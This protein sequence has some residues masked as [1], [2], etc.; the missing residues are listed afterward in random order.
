MI[1]EKVQELLR[2]QH[3][4]ATRAQLRHCGLTEAALAWRLRTQWRLVLPRVVSTGRGRLSE[5]QRLIAAMLFADGDAVV[6]SFAAAAWHGVTAAVPGGPVHLLV[7]PSRGLASTGFVVVRRTV[8]PDERPFRRGGLTV[9]S[10]ARAVADAARDAAAP[11]LARALVIEAA[12]RG[13][14]RLDDLRHELEAGPRQGSRLLRNAVQDAEAGAWSV[15]EAHL[16]RLCRSSRVL[17]EMWLNPDLV[18]HDGTCL[19]RPDGWF[20]DVA[21]AI[22]VHSREHHDGPDTWDDTVMADGLLGEYG[23]AVVPVTPRR[24]ARAPDVVL[25]RIERCYENARRRPRP[26][27]SALPVGHGVVSSSSGR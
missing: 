15:P 21:L 6:T 24:I 14:V 2:T 22:Q 27:V 13:I 12:Q 25:R 17:P 26:E 10:R 23:V 7:P 3:G 4:L 11:D 19:P 8:R 20:D 9:A 16:G 1:P 5:R 18:A